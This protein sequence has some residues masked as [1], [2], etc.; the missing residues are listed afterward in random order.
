MIKIRVDAGAP[1]EVLIGRGLFCDVHKLIGDICKTKRAAVVT[2]DVVDSLYGDRLVEQLKRG[3][4]SVDK[5]VFP[6]GEASKTLSTYGNILEFLGNSALTRADTVIALGGGVTG[7]LSG[8]AAATYLRGIKFIQIPTTLLA[9]VDSSVGG[10]TGVDLPVG[11]NLAGAFHQPSLVLCDPDLLESLDNK[12]FADGMS[13][14]LKCGILADKTLFDSIGGGSFDAEDVIARC[15]K[16]KAKIVGDDEFDRGE[17]ALLNLGH[18]I[19]HAIEKLSSF[20]VTHG[21]A[22][23]RGMAAVARASTAFGYCSS[24]C[25]AKISAAVASLGHPTDV[26]YGWEEIFGVVRH[27]KKR[28][29]DKTSLIVVRDIGKCEIVSMG[30]EELMKFIR[31]GIGD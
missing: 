19:G 25:A 8:F 7:D 9:A 3:G 11:K 18:T 4:Y 28:S 17:R 23:G 16:I 20:S 5:F 26:P 24:E 6:H 10:K 27:D 13:E 14:A 12:T 22:V 30:D 31:A 1:Y 15:V 2:D 21:E 29:G